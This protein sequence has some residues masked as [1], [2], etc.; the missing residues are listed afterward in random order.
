MASSNGKVNKK[1]KLSLKH[2]VEDNVTDNVP[3]LVE[4]I[5]LEFQNSNSKLARND[6][7]SKANSTKNSSRKK[8]AENSSP[9]VMTKKFSR[10]KMGNEKFKDAST[11]SKVPESSA[12][13]KSNR[14]IEDWIKNPVRERS[15]R[16]P[17]CDAKVLHSL[18]NNHLDSCFKDEGIKVLEQ[19]SENNI[20]KN[21]NV[22]QIESNIDTK[23]HS[24]DVKLLDVNRKKVTINKKSSEILI[25]CRG[26]SKR[27]KN[28]PSSTSNSSNTSTNI[29]SKKICAITCDTNMNDFNINIESKNTGVF[30]NL[31]TSNYLNQSSNKT[32]MSKS[33]DSTGGMSLE[34]LKGENNRSDIFSLATSSAD[35]SKTIMQSMDSG[36][37]VSLDNVEFIKNKTLQKSMSANMFS[38]SMDVESEASFNNVEPSKCNILTRQSTSKCENVFSESMDVESEASFNGVEPNKCNISTSKC[39]IA[40]E[41][42]DAASETSFDDAQ[43]NQSDPY[44]LANFKLVLDTVLSNEEDKSLFNE[45]DVAVIEKFQAFPIE[46]QKLYIRLFQRRPGW[47]RCSKIDYPK[48]AKDLK[49][50]LNDLLK[51]GKI[52]KFVR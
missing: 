46:C 50:V 45:E 14:T 15:V 19:N 27:R 4:N 22:I 44:Y 6:A 42:M 3:N 18:I 16:C 13:S 29:K 11:R 24:S 51:A 23:T 38:E 5:D 20:L 25:D 12:E 41:S 48:I 49:P 10:I 39:E 40:S 35:Q 47:F 7:Q 26:N 28:N 34:E 33:V 17:V 21:E 36:S 37:R 31:N 52:F 2:C 9:E 43:D 32:T 30:N 1:R 8:T